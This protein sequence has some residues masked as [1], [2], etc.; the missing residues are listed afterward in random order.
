MNIHFV[1]PNYPLK[2]QCHAN[3]YIAC[4]LS[5]ILSVHIKSILYM[6]Y[7]VQSAWSIIRV[8]IENNKTP[9]GLYAWVYDDDDYDDES[10]VCQK[11]KPDQTIGH[12]KASLKPLYIAPWFSHTR[13]IFIYVRIWNTCP[14]ACTNIRRPT[15]Q[16]IWPE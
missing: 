14:L 12:L 15:H 16:T 13:I 8:I 9:C 1:N 2:I 3:K 7:L 5:I 11:T 10:P 6:L 4:L